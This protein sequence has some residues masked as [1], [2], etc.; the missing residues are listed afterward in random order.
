M[1]CFVYIS[2][3]VVIVAAAA[4]D[5]YRRKQLSGVK[6]W[7]ACF[8]DTLCVIPRAL[9]LGVWKKGFARSITDILAKV[10][11]TT[12]LSDMGGTGEAALIERYDLMLQA[13]ITNSRAR[14][15][16][17]GVYFT[18]NTIEKR[19]TLRLRMIDFLKRHPDIEKIGVRKP[20]FVIGFPRTG[21][22]FLHELLGLHPE[23]RM[24]YSWEQMDPVPKTDNESMEARIADRKR[25]YGANR[26]ELEN[27]LMVGGDAIQSIHRI[28]YDEPE[29][30]TT[31]CAME[32]PWNIATIAFTVFAARELQ[33]LD[34]GQAFVLYRKF[35]QLMAWQAEDRQEPF[36]WMLKCPFHLPYLTELFSAFPDATVVWTHRDPAECIA[37]ACSLYETMMKLLVD[38]WTI[39]KH[40]L[41]Q[42]VMEYTSIALDKAMASVEKAS[43][44][45][46][47][48]HVRYADNVKDPKNICRQVFE[49]AELPFSREFEDRVDGYLAKNAEQ[50][51]KLKEQKAKE[52]REG[53]TTELHSYSLE[54]YGLSEEMVLQRFGPYISKYN[55]RANK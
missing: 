15:S 49:K 7:I 11:R 18:A 23:V 17:S 53:K 31:P 1:V 26:A 10:K 48:L 30:C 34:A 37:S 4:L 50:R 43:R 47:I 12:G 35:L 39:D 16:P 33:D 29:E 44:T 9:G 45:M 19:I 27:L 14:L 21:T 8:L 3:G 6:P 41:G 52:Q 24:H 46:K 28:G 25:R 36:T 54:E 32:L 5:T 38:S 20:V 51:K 42:A 2:L 13:G 22:T 55:L 40:A